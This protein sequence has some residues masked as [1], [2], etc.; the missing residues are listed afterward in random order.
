[1][2]KKKGIPTGLKLFLIALPFMIFVFMMAYVP[3]FGWLYAFTDYKVG[4]YFTDVDFIGFAQF[5]KLV[6]YK[7]EIF[8]VLG[9]TLA[10]SGLGLLTSPL[11]ILIAIMLNEVRSKKLKSFIQTVTTL[12]N[13]INWIV[14][15]GISFA[16]FSNNGLINTIMRQFGLPESTTG[17]M[18]DRDKVWFFQ[19]ALGNWKGLG[20]SAIVYLAAIAGIDSELY[21]AAMIDGANKFRRIYHITVPGILPTYLVLLIL[22]ISNILSNGFEQYFVFHNPLVASKIEVLDYFV[23]KVGILMKD[24]PLSIILGMIKSIIG[25]GLLFMANTLSKK[26]R[27]QSII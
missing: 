10:M 7:S 17:I 12:P 27:G 5:A 13:F 8:R 4:R 18:G 16:V 11:P 15:F 2:I 21:E 23:Y 6:K 24:Y 1:M 25:I 14:V 19:L 3:L 26:I 22:A 20:W 9:N